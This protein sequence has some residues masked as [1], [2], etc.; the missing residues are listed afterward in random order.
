MLFI[1]P[2]SLK[3][4]FVQ[5]FKSYLK[6]DF[7]KKL[8][9]HL[10]FPSLVRRKAVHARLYINMIRLEI[11][12]FGAFCF[13]AFQRDAS[14]KPFCLRVKFNKLEM[15]ADFKEIQ[16]PKLYSLASQKAYPTYGF[17]SPGLGFICPKLKY[18][19]CS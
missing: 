2:I 7:L 6:Y 11:L 18:P 8:H 19:V 17:M 13:R 5:L 1:P 4:H 12:M 15:K 16:S 10:H 9:I 3:T 14:Q